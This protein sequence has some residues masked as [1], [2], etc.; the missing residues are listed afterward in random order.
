MEVGLG[1]LAIS[2]E[3]RMLD[4]D[5]RARTENPL[6]FEFRKA[7]NLKSRALP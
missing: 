7:C 4:V 5:L 6:G 2:W 1:L 3:K